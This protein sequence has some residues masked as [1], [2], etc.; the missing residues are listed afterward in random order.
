MR[1]GTAYDARVIRPRTTRMT[2]SNDLLFGVFF[3][4]LGV[5]VAAAAVPRWGPWLGIGA[6]VA[7]PFALYG[8]FRAL[9]WVVDRI[10]PGR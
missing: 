9:A 4:A 1:D 5:G 8:L 6:G 10:V 2:G 7:T 3:L